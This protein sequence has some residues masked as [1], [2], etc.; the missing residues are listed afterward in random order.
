MSNDNRYQLE[1]LL[2]LS[3]SLYRWFD[4]GWWPVAKTKFTLTFVP[5]IDPTLPTEQTS[6]HSFHSFWKGTRVPP[7]WRLDYLL[8]KTTCNF[9]SIHF[10][11]IVEP[12]IDFF[13]FEIK[14]RNFDEIEISSTVKS[15]D[16]C[17]WFDR[18]ES[19]IR[20]LFEV[21]KK[22]EDTKFQGRIYQTNVPIYNNKSYKIWCQNVRIRSLQFCKKYIRFFCILL[23]FRFVSLFGKNSILN[24]K[25]LTS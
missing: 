17:S 12:M 9:P 5:A 13:L 2:E 14:K 6:S 3:L 10:G 7:S 22:I 24:T 16:N 15:V 21:K 20:V 18:R 19:K 1:Q 8:R 4:R 11:Y 23:S 25:C